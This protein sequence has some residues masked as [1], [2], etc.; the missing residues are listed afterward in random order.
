M[1]AKLTLLL[2]PMAGLCAGCEIL[3]PYLISE[4]VGD[5]DDVTDSF[6]APLTVS[7]ESAQG[8]ISGRPVTA[9]MF[10]MVGGER[11]GDQLTFR[12]ASADG[13][14]L[15]VTSQSEGSS[16]NPYTGEGGDPSFGDPRPV[17]VDGGVGMPIPADAFSSLI[18]CAVGVCRS[19]ST[20]GIEVEQTA[21]GRDALVDGTWVEGDVV[22]LSFHYTEE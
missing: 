14:E 15:Q 6:F 1:R 7:V 16:T 17:L 8:Q 3:G 10:T 22:E 9:E 2:L 19:A 13:I 20:F 21:D 12:F 5:E 11:F 18:T 4:A